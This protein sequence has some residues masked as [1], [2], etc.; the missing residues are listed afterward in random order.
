ML[1]ILSISKALTYTKFIFGVRLHLQNLHVKVRIST[2]SGQGQGQGQGHRSSI[3]VSVC[4]KPLQSEAGK[5]WQ[6]LSC[7]V[8]VGGLIICAVV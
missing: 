3:R 1:Y 2:S 4:R 7:Y 8:F 5:S 6:S